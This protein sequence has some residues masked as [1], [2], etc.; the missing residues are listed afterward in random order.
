MAT[1]K[2]FL[3]RNGP[4]SALNTKYFAFN[5]I[6]PDGANSLQLVGIYDVDNDDVGE[7]HKTVMG[8]KGP[9]RKLI[10]RLDKVTEE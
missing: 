7:F 4:E 1:T 3:Y 10:K 6:S 5:G 8:Y 9:Q 2:V